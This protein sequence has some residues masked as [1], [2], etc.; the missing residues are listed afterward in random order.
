MAKDPAMLW[1]WGD[2]HSGTTLMSRFLKGCYMDLLHAQF[3]NGPLSLDEVKTVLGGDFGQ[4]WPTLQKKFS[5][6]PKGLFFNERLE[7]EKNKRKAFSESRSKNRLNKTH[8]VS[9]DKHMNEHMINHMENE[10]ENRN[11]IKKSSLINDFINENEIDATIQYL[12]ITAQRSY[13]AAEILNYW[14]AFLII[15]EPVYGNRGLKINHFRNWLK[16]QDY[17]NNNGHTKTKKLTS[18]GDRD[19]AT[20]F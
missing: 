20:G 5:V 19:Y 2:W 1:Y 14:P 11:E 17:A 13:T 9:Y 4:A 10:N 18:A 6:N 12:K 7:F 15:Q 16:K 8:D 3:N